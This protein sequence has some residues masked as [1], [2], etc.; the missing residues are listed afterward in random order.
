MPRKSHAVPLLTAAA[1]VVAVLAAPPAQAGP[2]LSGTDEQAL[3]A[4]LAYMGDGPAPRGAAPAPFT[5][6]SKTADGDDVTVRLQQNLD[7]VPVFG[8]HTLVHLT[9]GAADAA[10]DP[11]TGRS[12]PGL[13]VSTTPTVASARAGSL[14]LASL[15]DFRTRAAAKVTGA[16]LVVLPL[17]AGVLAWRVSV[18]GLDYEKQTPLMRDVFVDAATGGIRLAYDT[19]EF[20]APVH[21]SGTAADGDTLPLEAWRNDAGAY[22]L[23]DRT[24]PMWDGTEGEVLTYDAEGG[25]YWDYLGVLPPDTPLVSGPTSTF[26]G[27]ATESG[28]VDAHWGAGQVYDFYR[29]NFGRDG[30]DGQGM[31]MVSVVGTTYFGRPFINA[32]WDGTKMVYGWANGEYRPLSADLDVVGHE[33]THGVISHSANLVYIGQ[34]GAMNEA[35]ADYFGNA[36]DVTV[37]GTPM[38]DP[39]AG[40]LGEDLCRTTPPAECAL[41]DLNDA[42]TTLDSFLGVTI[43]SDSGGVHLNSTIFSGALWDAREKLDPKVVDKVVYKALTEYMTPTDTF[44]DGRAAVEAAAKKLKLSKADQRVFSRAFDAHGIYP[45]WER[46]LGVD[47]R[48]LFKGVTDSQVMMNASG[49]AYAVTSSDE[50]GGA[51]AAVYAGSTDG[52]KARRISPDDGLWHSSPATD[53]RTV[54]W[55]AS[56]YV[57]DAPYA[58]VLA[59]SLKGGPVRVIAEARDGTSYASPT[60]DGDTIAYTANEVATFETEVYVKKG[61]AA[62]VKVTPGEGI[63]GSWLDLRGGRLGYIEVDPSGSWTYKPAVYDIASGKKTYFEAS[64]DFVYNKDVVLGSDGLSWVRDSDVDG[65]AAIM[66]ADYDGSHVRALIAEDAADA[67]FQ[68]V[69]DGSDLFLT[70][71]SRDKAGAGNAGLPKLHQ[72]SVYGGKPWRV[73]CNRGDQGQFA[74]DE[75]LRVVWLDGT[76]GSSDLVTRFFPAGRC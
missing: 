23:R 5:A 49:G 52:G 44:S 24:R 70:Y 38:S 25:N 27:R 51:P 47:S 14:A 40:L 75:F 55:E 22:E 54:V 26:T 57:D 60:V 32:F 68:P 8:A 43:R 76:T 7:G 20:A 63:Q 28:A 11:V 42:R 64:T 59:R 3:A 33:M 53:G 1:L 67:P 36:I 17:G 15:A 37:S 62:A 74:A 4:A 9:G 50:Q 21:G 69:L 48:V 46:D 31:T 41:R 65:T 19:V 73:S 66:R 45:G 12:Y 72:F 6:L 58:A 18:A 13:S 2:E 10:Q 16:Q 56:G 30:L 71:A 61:S 35:L 29:D 34:S 39:T